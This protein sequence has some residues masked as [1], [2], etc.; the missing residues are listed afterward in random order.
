MNLRS[1]CFFAFTRTTFD[2]LRNAL[3]DV[4]HL[5]LR[6]HHAHALLS[7]LQNRIE[8]VDFLVVFN[9]LKE[10]VDGD[11]SSRSTGSRAAVY[12]NASFVW[13]SPD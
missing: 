3:V 7:K 1:N 9:S 10:D 13:R 6:L 12:Q 11:E 8:H 2:G 5:S 4:A